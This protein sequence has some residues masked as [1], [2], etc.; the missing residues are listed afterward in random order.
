MTRGRRK[1]WDNNERCFRVFSLLLLLLC[2]RRAAALAFGKDKERH[3]YSVSGLS[4]L[5]LSFIPFAGQMALLT[6]S[7][8]GVD[9]RRSSFYFY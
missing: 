8:A 5:L 4:S 3:Q 7:M 9:L 6:L 2:G 1:A